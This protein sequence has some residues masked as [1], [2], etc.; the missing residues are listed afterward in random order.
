MP[1]YGSGYWILKKEHMR[2]MGMEE[3]HFFRA[4]AGNSR[5]ESKRTEEN[6]EELE[7]IYITTRIKTCQKQ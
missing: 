1:L 2:R 3:K 6:R 4:V 7:I 5:T